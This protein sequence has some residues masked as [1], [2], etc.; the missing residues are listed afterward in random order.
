MEIQGQEKLTK[1]EESI[2]ALFRKGYTNKEIGFVIGV[3]EKTIR[4]HYMTSIYR[5]FS[6][7]G[8]HHKGR[9]LMAMLLDMDL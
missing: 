5:K 1:R 8:V 3:N 9:K 2:L 7:T 4:Q 6:V